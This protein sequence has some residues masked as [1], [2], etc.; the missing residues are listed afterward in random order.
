MLHFSP[1][2]SWS[3]G[4]DNMNSLSQQP[5]DLPVVDYLQNSFLQLHLSLT[6]M[7][8]LPPGLGG[9]ESIP[10]SLK[11]NWPHDT[12]WPKQC[13]QNDIMWFLGLHLKRFSWFS[14]CLLG[15]QLPCQEAWATSLKDDRPWGDRERVSQSPAVPSAPPEV[16][17]HVNEVILAPPPP[18][19]RTT[20]NRD[21]P[22]PGQ[23]TELWT[24][25]WL[26][27]L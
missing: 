22:S 1:D 13:S 26:W 10:L 18:V 8:F 16:T 19:K 24:A 7:P 4:Q 11:L 27:L 17:R 23:P 20:G 15:I 5:K 21:Q 2:N 12:L 3:C 6:H 14:F 25:K 9:W